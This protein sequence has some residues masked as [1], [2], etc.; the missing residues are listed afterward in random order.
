MVGA[1]FS[2]LPEHKGCGCRAPL[3]CG[4]HAAMTPGSRHHSLDYVELTVTDLAAAKAFYTQAFGWRFVDYGPEYAGIASSADDG[5]EV[6]GL[7]VASEPRPHGG[8]FVLLYSDDLDE[9]ERAIVRAGGRIVQE[10][11]AFPGGRRLHFAD[12]SGN[13]LGV[14]AE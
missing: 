11:Y 5:G 9:T 13:E 14:W 6:G 3:I 4:Y 1:P 7:L 12:P 8:P 2:E 10:P